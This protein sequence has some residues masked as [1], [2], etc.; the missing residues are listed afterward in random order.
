METLGALQEKVDA[1]LDLVKRLKVLNAE[2]TKEN[3]KLSSQLAEITSDRHT[4]QE[5]IQKLHEEKNQT[6]LVVEDLIK[7]I[8][9]FINA[10]N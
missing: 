4:T 8:D 6:K 9:T 2:L 1:L 5:D 7:S 10:Q 3:K